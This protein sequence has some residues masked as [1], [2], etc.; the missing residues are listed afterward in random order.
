[1]VKG[2][3]FCKNF[4]HLKELVRSQHVSLRLK[5]AF[6]IGLLQVGM[7]TNYFLFVSIIR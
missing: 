6:A 5:M 4:A 3:F 1:M 7:E 2:E